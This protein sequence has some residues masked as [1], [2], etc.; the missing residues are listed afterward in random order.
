[1]YLRVNL[2]REMITEGVFSKFCPFLQIFIR[3]KSCYDSN[4]FVIKILV[5]KL[6]LEQFNPEIR[7][8]QK[9]L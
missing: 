1:M 8:H 5:C 6:I 2:R 7:T 9:N 4:K 3:I